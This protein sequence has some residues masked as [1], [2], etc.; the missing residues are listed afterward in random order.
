MERI[1]LM[2]FRAVG[3]EPHARL[4]HAELRARISGAHDRE[5]HQVDGFAFGVRAR[6]HQNDVA[7]L[8]GGKDGTDRGAGD[9][10]DTAHAK[11]RARKD[12][13]RGTCGNE[14]DRLF[15]LFQ[16]FQGDHQRG[17]LFLADGE[18]RRVVVGDDFRAVHDLQ[19][20]FIVFEGQG[21]V[22]AAAAAFQDRFDLF[23][24]ARNDDF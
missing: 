9:A 13:A 2:L 3:D 11:Q 4:F 12:R 14:P 21:V 19:T 6:V 16:K 15:V 7:A 5:M 17:I 8:C 24:I 18:G 20:F 1:A 23:A 10:A 22:P